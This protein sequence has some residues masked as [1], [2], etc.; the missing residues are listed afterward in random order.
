MATL[1]LAAP[2]PSAT[3][4][5]QAATDAL[6]RLL[7]T[8]NIRVEHQPV[9]TAMFDTASRTLV[10]PVW[11][12]MSQDLYDM[13]V[14]H[15]V[16]HA[17]WTPASDAT[18][19]DAIRR[20]RAAGAPSDAWAKSILNIVE[21]ARIERKIKEKFPG[22]RRNFTIAYRELIARDIFGLAETGGDPNAKGFVDR[23]NLYHKCGALGLMQVAFDS[24]EQALVNRGQ[25]TESFEDVVRLCEDICAM[26]RD[27]SNDNE[28]QDGE[29]NGAG[30][31][32]QSKP[33]QQGESQTSM[34]TDA[35][36][37]EQGPEAQP[38]EGAAVNGDDADGEDGEQSDSKAPK[39]DKGGE[40]QSNGKP[41]QSDTKSDKQDGQPKQAGETGDGD[42]GKGRDAKDGASIGENISTDDKMTKGLG[43]MADTNMSGYYHQ[44]GEAPSFQMDRLVVTAEDVIALWRDEFAKEP[45]ALP[46]LDSLYEAWKRD[47]LPTVTNMVKRFEQRKAADD[48]KRT[49]TA[50]SGRIDTSRLAYYKVSE[51]LFLSMT[52]TTDGKSHGLVMLID[53]S[54]SMSPVLGSVVSQVLC[55]VEFCRKAGVPYE[56]YAFSDCVSGWKKGEK[57]SFDDDMGAYLVAKKQDGA[58]CPTG[59][60]MVQFLRSGMSRADHADAVRGMVGVMALHGYEPFN[61]LLKTKAEGVRSAPAG[62]SYG[63]YHMDFIRTLAPKFQAPQALSL[64]GTPLNEGLLACAD[65]VE[66]FRKRTGAQIVNLAVLTDGEATRSVSV[67]KGAA[68]KAGYKKDRSGYDRYPAVVLRWGSKQYPFVEANPKGGRWGRQV[69]TD[70]IIR[71]LRDRTGARV[72][73]FYLM[74]DRAATKTIKGGHFQFPTPQAQL[75]AAE[76]LDSEGSCI[77][78]HPAYDEYYLVGIASRTEDEDFLDRLDATALSARK[79]ASSFAKGMTN[80]ST[81]RTIMVRFT[82]CFATGK[83]SQHKM[84]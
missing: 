23:F 13:L 17:L 84:R 4:N 21:D 54:G 43:Q 65:L 79:I 52:T 78:P 62:Y 32:G 48:A 55:L 3:R 6:A 20:V 7:A 27:E 9:P 67:Y 29:G 47:N 22:I 14:G 76:Q 16:G 50:K 15:E 70:A 19:M 18:V 25:T 41:E 60:R 75:A 34:P 10:L 26:L 11:R 81:S 46:M 36:D 24:Q 30:K 45:A 49:M 33:G 59:F 42:T 53:W 74:S 5:A 56:V 39:G 77:V 58:L 44:Y 69:E 83:P 73:G 68:A 37:A 64:N 72:Y 8:E 28:P 38:G 2:N 40:S 61:A 12:G 31:P 66:A 1:S 35:D 57:V 51:D 71:Y 82:D 63:Y 80:R